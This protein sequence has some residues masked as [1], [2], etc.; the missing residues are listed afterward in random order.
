M[1]IVGGIVGN[2]RFNDV[3][4]FQLATATHVP[5]SDIPTEFSLSQNYPN[6]FNPTTNI[7]FRIADFGFVTLKIYDML[8]RN[9]A[10]LMNESLPP[11]VYRRTWDGSGYPSGLYYYRLQTSNFLDTKTMTLLK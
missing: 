8:G 7:E 3:W 10:T 5:L 2:L 6:P 4:E 1:I 9:I 11:G